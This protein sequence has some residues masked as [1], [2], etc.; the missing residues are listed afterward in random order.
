MNPDQT[1]HLL[2]K[3]LLIW[4]HIVCN[5]GYQSITAD[6]QTDHICDDWQENGKTSVYSLLLYFVM[7]LYLAF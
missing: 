2:F 6:G 3:V 1:F 7:L 4:V 5:M